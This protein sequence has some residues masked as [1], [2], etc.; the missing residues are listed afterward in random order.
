MVDRPTEED[1]EGLEEKVA[2]G[3]GDEVID[4]LM[5]EDNEGLEEELAN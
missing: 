1:T 2:N 3:L 5:E 4:G